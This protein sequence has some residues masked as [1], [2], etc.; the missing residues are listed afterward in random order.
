MT[1]EGQATIIKVQRP[2][3]PLDQN[4]WLFYNKSRSVTYQGPPTPMV[5]KLMGKDFKMYV[6]AKVKGRKVIIYRRT[7]DQPW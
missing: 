4:N 7:K 2:L 6:R 5:I 1:W 3:F